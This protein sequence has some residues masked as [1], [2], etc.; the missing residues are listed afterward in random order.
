[1]ALLK[2]K[3]VLGKGATNGSIRIDEEFVPI[4]RGKGQIEVTDVS[5][6]HLTVRFE[7]AVGS[8]LE[9][10]VLQD[11]TS[12]AKA[13]MAISP[14][15]VEGLADGTFKLKAAPKADSNEPGQ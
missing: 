14:G 15:Q 8:T 10:E 5:Q 7:G 3:F 11:V 2:I 4:R 1:M 13:K 6:H 12:L 9:F